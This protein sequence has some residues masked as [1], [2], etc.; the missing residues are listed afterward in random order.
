MG[1]ESRRKLLEARRRQ[2]S[3]VEA[4]LKASPF[5]VA[6]NVSMARNQ[7][8]IIATTDAFIRV[9]DRLEGV[10]GQLIDTREFLAQM[11]ASKV[12]SAAMNRLQNEMNK[13]ML[14]IQ[15]VENNLQNLESKGVTITDIIGDGNTAS[16]DEETL[17]IQRLLESINLAEATGDSQKATELKN[18]YHQRIAELV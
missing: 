15:Q 13:A 11:Q 18:Q 8:K 4:N 3:S 17:E 9:Y 10:Y 2:Y 16:T 14:T 5:E 12:D 1:L 7:T 6:L